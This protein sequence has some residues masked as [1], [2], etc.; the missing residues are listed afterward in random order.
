[1]SEA[2]ALAC[3]ASAPPDDSAPETIPAGTAGDN[4]GGST[5]LTESTFSDR[6]LL[7]TF[8]KQ[9]GS[10][11][12]AMLLDRH[13]SDLLRTASALLGDGDL[14]QDAVQEAFLRLGRDAATVLK[15]WPTTSNSLGG[16]L[17]TV[18]RNWCIDQI[19]RRRFVTMNDDPGRESSPATA[20]AEREAG[21]T[22]WRSV[23]SLP[24]LERAAVLLRYRDGLSY[25]DIAD[26]IGK[27]ATH[28]GVLLHQALGRLRTCPVLRQEV[29]T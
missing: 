28:V 6:H 13:Q 10:T 24:P 7:E 2:Q 1:M 5:E 20:V 29:G 27:S 11:A 14:A 18:V 15:N 4:A 8:C 22:L 25:Q 26:H 21:D 17:A 16:W 23:S 3:D 19:R 9:R 12:F